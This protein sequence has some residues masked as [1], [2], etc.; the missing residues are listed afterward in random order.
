MSPAHRLRCLLG[1]I[2]TGS[3]GLPGRVLASGRA[4]L[5]APTGGLACERANLPWAGK[6]NFHASAISNKNSF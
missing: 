4:R 6:Y 3:R 1:S 5:A 2:G